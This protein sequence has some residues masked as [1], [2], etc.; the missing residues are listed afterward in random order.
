MSHIPSM[1]FPVPFEDLPPHIQE[2]IMRHQ[3]SAEDYRHG[4]AR[5]FEESSKEHLLV[6]QA[7]FHNISGTSEGGGA[8][9]ASYYEGIIGVTLQKRFNICLACGVD[10]D[11]ALKDFTGKV[12]EG[13]HP[14]QDPRSDPPHPD[15]PRELTPEDFKNMKEYG[16]DDLRDKDLKILGFVCVNCR[17]PYVSI[18]DRMKQPP[19][20]EGCSGCRQMAKFG[21][22]QGPN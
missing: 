7:I 6:L 16:L 2:E 12:D 19:G 13:G 9:L 15:G 14:V 20:P 10:H 18:E 1:G 11:E 5:L 3:A 21:G 22:K 4:V 17:M 8:A